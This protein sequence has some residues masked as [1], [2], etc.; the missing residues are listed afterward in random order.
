MLYGGSNRSQ[1]LR[2]IFGICIAV[3][4]LFNAYIATY[5]HQHIVEKVT[6]DPLT[7]PFLSGSGRNQDFSPSS[8]ASRAS[9]ATLSHSLISSTPHQKLDRTK[10]RRVLFVHIGKT[11]GE[12]IRQTLRVACRMRQNPSLQESCLQKFKNDPSLGKTPLNQ[13]TIGTIHCLLMVPANALSKASTLLVSVR[14]PI[15]RVISWFRYLHPGNCNPLVDKQSTACNVKK[16]LRRERKEARKR[17]KRG[18]KGG[19][20]PSSWITRFFQCFDSLPQVGLALKRDDAS[21]AAAN[22]CSALAQKTIRGAASPIS[23]H[24]YFNYEYYWNQTLALGPELETMV[25]RTEYL[26]EDLDHVQSLLHDDGAENATTTQYN[27]PPRNN[28]T[29][30]SESHRHVDSISGPALQYLCCAL[31]REIYFYVGW[32]HRAVNLD[33]VHKQQALDGVTKYCNNKASANRD[34][35]LVWATTDLATMESMLCT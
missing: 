15:E 23:S 16:A 26:W 22:N 14:N 13:Q 25:V 2:F 24:I 4:A 30:G 19:D 29:H 5:H 18:T 6:T 10:P 1:R 12:T 33:V 3:V 20:K 31:S 21:L 8:T 27:L 32:I 11:G 9:S 17:Q 35:F 28:H 7:T 34:D